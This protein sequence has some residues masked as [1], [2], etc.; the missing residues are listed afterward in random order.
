VPRRNCWSRRPVS[1]RL[2]A[3]IVCLSVAAGAAAQPPET[4]EPDRPDVTNGTHIVDTGLLQVEFGAAYTS[5]SSGLD[6]FGSPFTARLGVLDW[7]E[8]RFGGDGI[9]VQTDAIGRESGFGNLQVGAKLRLWDDPGGVPVLSILPTVNVPT[10]DAE[11]GLGSGDADYTVSILSGTD[12]GKRA[13]VDAN[14]GIG[15]IGAG[16]GAPHFVQHAASVSASARATTKWNPYLEVFWFS[17]QDPGGGPVTAIDG[18]AIYT[19]TPR[20]AFDGGVQ[21]GLSAAAPDTVVFGGVSVVVGEILGNHG[22]HA[23]QRRPPVMRTPH[24]K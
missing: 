1:R 5:I 23:R 17:R 8:L 15:A 19:V 22:A 12:L 2:G 10:A 4:I 7:L 18:G 16:G 20:L 9:L 3:L 11:K 14:Y 13:H 6:Q 24:R 21:A